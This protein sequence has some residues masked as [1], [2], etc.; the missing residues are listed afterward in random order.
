MIQEKYAYSLS[1]PHWN[2]III[3]YIYTVKAKNGYV[4]G[5]EFRDSNILWR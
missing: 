5:Q 1:N 4:T 3:K 2:L